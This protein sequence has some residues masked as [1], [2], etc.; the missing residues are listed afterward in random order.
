VIDDKEERE[1]ACYTYGRLVIEYDLLSDQVFDFVLKNQE[2]PGE[3]AEAVRVNRAA[4]KEARQRYLDAFPD[5]D[6]RKE[7][8]HDERLTAEHEQRRLEIL[9]LRRQ[10]GPKVGSNG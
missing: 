9:K 1:K 4:H 3:L 8:E 10:D 2:P 6:T 7:V 5:D